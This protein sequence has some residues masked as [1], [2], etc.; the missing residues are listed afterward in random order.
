MAGLKAPIIDCD[1]FGE[2]RWQDPDQGDTHFGLSICFS[3]STMGKGTSSSAN[4][5]Q[6]RTPE[7][8]AASRASSYK[9]W[10]KYGFCLCIQT[11]TEWLVSTGI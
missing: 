5:R 10:H 8:R 1:P 7:Q 9:N 6:K 11:A 4:E 3:S 2:R